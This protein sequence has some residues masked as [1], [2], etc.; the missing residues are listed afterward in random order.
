MAD[1]GSVQ[2]AAGLAGSLTIGTLIFL[3][4]QNLKAFVPNL[5]GRP[6]EATVVFVAALVTLAAFIT[7]DADWFDPETIIAYIVATLSASVIARSTYAALF[8][9]S[10]AGI[11]PSAGATVQPE[12]VDDPNAE[13]VRDP[14]TL[15]ATIG[16]EPVAVRRTRSGKAG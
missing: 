13:E 12:A 7:T 1:I 2:I 4:M 16:G 6:A 14:G 8:K 9:V 11:P 5:S 15:S 3:V 10:V